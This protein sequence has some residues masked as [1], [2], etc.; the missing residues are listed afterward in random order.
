M[1]FFQKVRHRLVPEPFLL[2]FVANAAQSLQSSQLHFP[3][4][5]ESLPEASTLPTLRFPGSVQS[6]ID[7]LRN[8]RSTL[9]SEITDLSEIQSDKTIQIEQLNEKLK[10]LV[11]F[12]IKNETDAIIIAGTT[13][14]AATLS[15]EEKNELFTFIKEKGKMS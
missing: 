6:D 15:K 3:W 1:A 7:R 8:E 11:E 5:E 12:H 13:G 2:V 14:E 10:E 4:L 9:R